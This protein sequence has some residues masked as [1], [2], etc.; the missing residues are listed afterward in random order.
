MAHQTHYALNG[1]RSPEACQPTRA[2]P[3]ARCQGLKNK[4]YLEAMLHVN[5]AVQ[6]VAVTAEWEMYHKLGKQEMQTLPAA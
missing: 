5:A 1:N 2:S 3:L 6:K 4:S